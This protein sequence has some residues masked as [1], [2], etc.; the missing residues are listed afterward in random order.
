MTKSTS[1]ERSIQLVTPKVQVS[2]STTSG[3]DTL[4]SLKKMAED[5]VDKYDIK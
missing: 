5:L 1:I 3:R 4:K 2:I